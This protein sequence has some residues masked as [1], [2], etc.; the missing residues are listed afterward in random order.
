MVVNSRSD[1][2]GTFAFAI[3]ENQAGEPGT[4]VVDLNGSP[5]EVG[6]YAFTPASPTTLDPSTAYFVVFKKT[7]AGR[8]NFIP[9]DSDAEDEGAAANWSI[10]D[11]SLGSTDSGA[12]WVART[13]SMKIAIKGSVSS[14]GTGPPVARISAVNNTIFENTEMVEF[15]VNLNKDA[16][17]GGIYV[18]VMVSHQGTYAVSPLAPGQLRNHTVNIAAGQ[19]TGRLTLQPINNTLVSEEKTV[20]G[21]VQSGTGYTVGSTDSANVVVQDDDT[22]TLEFS[23]DCDQTYTVRES[24]GQ[25]SYRLVITGG[26]V[27][28]ALDVITETVNGTAVAADDYVHERTTNAFQARGRSVTGTVAI[29]N[30]AILEPGETFKLRVVSDQLPAN[31]N[32]MNCPGESDPTATVAITDEDIVILT[33]R[34]S[35][36]EVVEGNPITV[37][38][39]AT[40]VDG[41][42]PLEGY[43][44][45]ANLAVSGATTVLNSPHYSGDPI[46][47]EKVGCGD[48]MIVDGMD[49]EDT[50][51]PTDAGSGEGT[52]TVTFTL[53]DIVA[54]G[55]ATELNQRIRLSP[56]SKS[57]RVIDDPCTSEGGLRFNS[58][59]PANIDVFS[60]DAD[61]T[62]ITLPSWSGHVCW[63]EVYL[64]YAGDN[65]LQVYHAK[66]K[67]MA[68]TATTVEVNDGEYSVHQA[69]RELTIKMLSNDFGGA[70]WDVEEAYVLY[71]FDGWT[72]NTTS[73]VVEQVFRIRMHNMRRPSAGYGQTGSSVR[74][75]ASAGSSYSPYPD[76]PYNSGGFEVQRCL[77]STGC[78][79]DTDWTRI[80]RTSYSTG[81]DWSLDFTTTVPNPSVDYRYRTRQYVNTRHGV[82]ELNGP[83]GSV[84]TSDS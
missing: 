11:G 17:A 36:D 67:T 66:G 45:N 14:A 81:T 22:V 23:I 69:T 62:T 79:A 65:Q 82:G 4:K 42:C 19:R 53:R 56:S 34:F 29:V 32:V 51:F 27:E 75:T 49:R 60:D 83:W 64:G 21:T 70:F 15:D 3:H 52:R 33:L 18:V 57:V 77:S 54:E 84:W 9:T 28:Y 41:E 31:V 35:V 74:I 38:M 50:E 13:G 8:T 40:E 5:S 6:Q 61:G 63:A 26:P 78:A 24:A 1:P 47:V 10:G 80:R 76:H 7:T 73:A 30:D 44:L 46:P 37:K 59:I 12:N 16:P 48:L 71:P 2:A 25:V 58:T 20:V 39:E 55:H 68:G 43:T 72:Y